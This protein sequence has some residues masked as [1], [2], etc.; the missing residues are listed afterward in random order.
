VPARLPDFLPPAEHFAAGQA[1]SLA[2]NVLK[3]RRMAELRGWDVEERSAEATQMLRD[4]F[5][6]AGLEPHA[7]ETTGAA[8]P[9]YAAKLAL[10]GASV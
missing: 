10:A 8:L 3:V 4:L 1:D 7:L 5:G 9:V 2:V 6:L